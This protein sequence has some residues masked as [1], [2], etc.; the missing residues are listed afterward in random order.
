MLEHIIYSNVMKH[1]DKYS[2]LSDC[3]QGFRARRSCKTQ[4]V[5][6]QHDLASTLDKGVQTDMVVLDFSKA[7][8]RIPHRRL[9]RKL[10]HYGIRGNINQWITS[11]ILGRTQR[12]TV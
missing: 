7:F 11:F 9:P 3:Q 6:L 12:V 10:L 5:T 8:D 4:L 2:I 1:V